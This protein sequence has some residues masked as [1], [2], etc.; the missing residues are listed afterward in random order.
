MGGIFSKPSA[1]APTPVAAPAAEKIAA[2]ASR[3]EEEAG[4][5]MRGSKRRGRQLLSDARLSAE[6]GVETLGSGQSL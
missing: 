6:A 5:K 4:A 3:T 1:P 2:Q